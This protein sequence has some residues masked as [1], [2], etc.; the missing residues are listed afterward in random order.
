L[1]VYKQS[2]NFFLHSEYQ[3]TGD[4]SQAIDALVIAHNKTLA[5]QFYGEFK[6]IF[7]E[8]VVEYFVY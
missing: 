4:R 8:N 1:E 6:E 7:L 2:W 3:P 5:K